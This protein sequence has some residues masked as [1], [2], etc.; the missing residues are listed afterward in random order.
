MPRTW[1]DLLTSEEIEALDALR[2]ETRSDPV[3]RNGTIILMSDAGRSKTSI[4][5]ELGCG[6]ATVERVR[7]LYRTRGIVGLTPN[8][9]PGRPSRLSEA[10]R[11]PMLEAVQTDPRELG[12]GFATWSVARLTEH[13]W[14]RCRVRA[15]ASTVRRVLAHQRFSLQR[16]SHTA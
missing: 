12:Y 11:E 5:E 1:K 10:L 2:L 4:A 8:K 14:R 7:R 6:T 9:P 13:L 3:F 16:P 15:S